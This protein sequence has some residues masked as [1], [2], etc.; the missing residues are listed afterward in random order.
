MSN[1]FWV[2]ISSEQLFTTYIVYDGPVNYPLYGY[3]MD[4]EVHVVQFSL[5]PQFDMQP[6]FCLLYCLFSFLTCLCYIK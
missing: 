2:S 6:V 4:I 1:S 5:L 3:I